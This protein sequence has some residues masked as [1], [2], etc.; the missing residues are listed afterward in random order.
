MRHSGDGLEIR[1]AL[2]IQNVDPHSGV[3]LVIVGL[4]P[5]VVGVPQETVGITS[6]L[7]VKVVVGGIELTDPIAAGGPIVGRGGSP[8]VEYGGSCSRQ[9]NHT[10]RRL[11]RNG[12]TIVY[13]LDLRHIRLR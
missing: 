4:Q 9:R 2:D 12:G 11:D 5:P 13:S 1:R 7:A 10:P 8:Q 6:T 3:S